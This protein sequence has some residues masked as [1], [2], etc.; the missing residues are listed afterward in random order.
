MVFLSAQNHVSRVIYLDDRPHLGD[1]IKLWMGSSRGR[2]E[3]DTLVVDVTQP[4]LEGRFDMVGNFASDQ[5]RVTERWTIVDANTL[6]Y[7][8]T[9]EDPTVYARPWTIESRVVRRS[10]R[11]EAY[12]DELWEDACHE[13]E[14]SVQHMLLTP[15]TAERAR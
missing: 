5:V 4:E 2:W 11:R 7:R 3:G 10:P 8:A 13:G 1:D 15:E 12:G 9:I 14:R 6:R